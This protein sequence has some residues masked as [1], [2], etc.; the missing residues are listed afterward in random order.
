[1]TSDE[2]HYAPGP[3]CG[4]DPGGQQ[5]VAG[6]VEE[7]F[8][9]V[10][11]RRLRQAPPV[12]HQ[13]VGAVPVVVLRDLRV[14]QVG[15]QTAAQQLSQLRPGAAQMCELIAASKSVSRSTN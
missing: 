6:L 14:A 1:M 13:A 2:R 7:L 9:P 15:R 12:V 8:P 10:R 4:G 3:V 11:V 5:L